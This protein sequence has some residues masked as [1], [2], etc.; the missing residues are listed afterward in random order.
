MASLSIGGTL[1]EIPTPNAYR[2]RNGR[3]VGRSLSRRV[4]FRDLGPDVLAPDFDP[5]AS[6][7]RIHREAERE[8]GEVLIDQRIIA[9]LGNVFKS[10]VCFICGVN[11]FSLVR[12]LTDDQILCL[13]RTAQTLMLA[14]VK[15]SSAGGPMRSFEYRRTT[16]RS[17]PAERV[18]VYGR[19]GKSCLKC[20]TPIQVRKQNPDARTIFWCPQCQQERRV[21]RILFE[22]T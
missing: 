22:N 5:S 21:Q 8:I 18:W 12:M 4:G 11:P 3:R 20:D 7:Q 15:D 1:A 14:N 13:T 6:A 17:H 2:H 16:G 19:T 9:G 10:E